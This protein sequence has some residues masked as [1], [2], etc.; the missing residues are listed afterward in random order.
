[1]LK[2]GYKNV[3]EIFRI[4]FPEKQLSKM[5]EMFALI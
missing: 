3:Q 1:M 5:A 2:K 4:N